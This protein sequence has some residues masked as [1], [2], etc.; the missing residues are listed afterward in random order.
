MAVV[1]AL[2]S[3]GAI[4]WLTS[5]S[6]AIRYLTPFSL[7][8]T[9]AIAGMF[10][11]GADASRFAPRLAIVSIVAAAILVGID[12]V[13]LAGLAPSTWRGMPRP[14][15]YALLA[16]E[17]ARRGLGQAQFVSNSPRDAG[18]IIIFMPEARAL[19]ASSRLESPPPDPLAERPCVLIWTE[20]RHKA[21]SGER[22]LKLLGIGSESGN[23]EEVVVN[24]KP[25]FG[26]AQ[27]TTWHLLRGGKAE[28]A[29]RRVAAKGDL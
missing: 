10:A 23:S 22:F 9:L 4:P 24:W 20:A 21:E 7:I 15:P 13:G 27:Q 16:E 28:R 12:F 19:A 25:P 29:C 11:G 17:L 1:T 5:T 26:G 8:A 14:I 2:V 18:N 6:Y 3:S